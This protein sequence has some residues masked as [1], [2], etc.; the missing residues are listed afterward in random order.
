MT[1]CEE[2]KNFLYSIREYLEKHPVEAEKEFMIDQVDPDVFG[3]DTIQTDSDVKANTLMGAPK[4]E[5][6]PEDKPFVRVIAIHKRTHKKTL[7][8]VQLSTKQDL[9]EEVS[10]E[11]KLALNT[12]VKEL[13][14]K[15]TN[16]VIYSY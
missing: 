8:T 15:Y 12:K 9:G 4:Y 5:K 1:Q 13:Q 6:N 16:Y 3:G 2:V 14:D 10:D 7:L 11:N